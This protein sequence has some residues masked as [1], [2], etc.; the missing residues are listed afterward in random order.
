MLTATAFVSVFVVPGLRQLLLTTGWPISAYSGVLCVVLPAGCL[1]VALVPSIVASTLASRGTCQRT[2]ALA[3]W[4]AA[5]AFFI[6]LSDSYVYRTFG[7]H[8][9][10][11]WLYA[12]QGE[13]GVAV[14]SFGS[15]AL[16]VGFWLACSA[17]GA[18]VLSS[19]GDVIERWCSKRS[20]AVS[21]VVAA[22]GAALAIALASGPWFLPV[23]LS[24]GIRPRLMGA[25]LFDPS[26][27]FG[28]GTVHED[29]RLQQLEIAFNREYAARFAYV[30]GAPD[31]AAR[32]V[33]PNDHALPNISLVVAES[34]RRD[35]FTPERMPRIWRWSD[36][37]LR[38]E[39]HYSGANHSETGMFTLLFGRSALTY[40][41]TLNAHA[42]PSL[43][44]S[45]RRLAYTCGYFTGHPK[46]WVRREEFLN[47][48]TM[49]VFEQ[50]DRGSW[51]D[52]DERALRRAAAFLK[53]GPRRLAITFLMSS[54]YEYRYPLA[55]RRH[56]PDTPP[57]VSWASLEASPDEFASS[58]NRYENVVEYLDDLVASH[59]ESL[60]R[61][62]TLAIFTADHGE[63]T[64]ENGRFGHGYGF[65]DPLTHVPFVLVGPQIEPEAR[66]ERSV[67]QD[68]LPTV[69]DLLGQEPSTGVGE[70]LLRPLRRDAL[71]L[72]NTKHDFRTADALLLSGTVRLGLQFDLE[73]PRLRLTGFE[74]ALGR[75]IVPR[76]GTVDVA[77]L[78]A[79]FA[80][81]L[82]RAGRSPP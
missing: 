72:V 57:R 21:S 75:P 10:D 62:S 18:W 38:F 49:D 76:P 2:P 34:L 11:L 59:V 64:G 70:S 9:G 66:G 30:F 50:D 46:R 61:A 47:E 36:A 79:Q 44:Q 1:T 35:V 4:L 51:N 71:L 43:C 68:L 22:A 69:L 39:H 37:G 52:W 42:W 80:D 6:V 14:G 24:E 5:A 28:S 55:Y 32:L 48:R 12:K 40:H 33:D 8:L 41:S 19:L 74:D 20:T 29:D 45:L 82:T 56:V 54:H 73:L 67:H 81:Q 23:S 53:G 17:G 27:Q 16:R 31:D 13:G 3:V 63:E 65:S 26:P 15:W 58:R 25:L 60:D 77:R 7:R 78:V